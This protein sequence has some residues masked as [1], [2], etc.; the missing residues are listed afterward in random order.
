MNLSALREAAAKCRGCELYKNATQTVFGMGPR[1]ADLMLVGEMPGDGEDLAGKPFVGPA[2]KLL[3]EALEESAIDR[4]RVYVTNAVKH[5]RWEPHGKRRLHKKPS[6]R[7]VTACKPWL[8]AEIRVVEPRLILCLG[9]TAAL[10]LLGS[11]FRLTQHRGELVPNEWGTH[12]M[13]TYHPSA[14]LRA[15]DK[16]DR[17][18][19]RHEFVEDL[20]YAAQHLQSES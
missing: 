17:D 18:R 12:V 16:A 19:K 15:P 20:R 7:Q 11:K 4:R 8:Q 1:C 14:I 13:A 6:S 2:G 5:F 9:A 10:S 3:D